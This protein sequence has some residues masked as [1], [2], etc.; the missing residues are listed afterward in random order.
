[1]KIDAIQWQGVRVPFREP[2]VTSAGS[3]DARY[4]LLV[5]L[6]GDTGVTGVGEAP[7][8][9]YRGEPALKRLAAALRRL[10][11]SLLGSTIDDLSRRAGQQLTG[12][13]DVRTL[14]F[15][16]ETAWLDALGQSRGIPLSNLLEGRP[17]SVP[18][19][20]VIATTSPERASELAARAVAQGFKTLKLK[21]G[22]R[23]ISRDEAALK[24][25]RAAVGR[26]VTLR[27]DAN[28]AWGVEEAMVNLR[29]LSA[30][31]PEYIEEPIASPDLSSLTQIRRYSPIPIAADESLESPADALRI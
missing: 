9:L 5:R 22:G 26:E 12:N 10:S 6:H 14:R 30:F 3:L 27:L 23:P 15:A 2:F 4:S 16:L 13:P 19:N 17:R 24:A 20:A 21:V 11:T 25:V 31:D 7:S 8:D 29:L 28:R 18:V 1:M